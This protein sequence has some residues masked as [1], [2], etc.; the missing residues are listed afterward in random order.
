MFPSQKKNVKCSHRSKKK[1]FLKSL[2]FLFSF[3]WNFKVQSTHINSTWIIITIF[4]SYQLYKTVRMLVIY[5]LARAC[6]KCAMTRLKQHS[7]V[8]PYSVLTL[9]LFKFNIFCL[10]AYMP[11]ACPKSMGRIT[12]SASAVL[13]SFL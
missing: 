11:G 1:H 8:L 12:T 4:P 6:S 9:T 7:L 10:V 13:S 3:W 5:C 2:F